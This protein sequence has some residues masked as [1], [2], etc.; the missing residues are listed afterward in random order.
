VELLIGA[1]ASELA[2]VYQEIDGSEQ[3]VIERLV[4]LLI[5]TWKAGPVPAHSLAYTFP[6]APLVQ[7]KAHEV[8]LMGSPARAL[9]N[10]ASDIYLSPAGAIK[11]IGAN[12]CGVALEDKSVFQGN[13]ARYVELQNRIAQ[14]PVALPNRETAFLVL[15]L[16]MDENLN[17]L[18]DASLEDV[19]LYF[20]LPVPEEH[21]K[22][23][24]SFLHELKNAQWFLNGNQVQAKPGLPETVL[25]VREEFNPVKLL[26]REVRGKYNNHFF[27]FQKDAVLK[28]G[29]T[30][31]LP[32]QLNFSLLRM[33]HTFLAALPPNPVVLTIRFQK[34]VAVSND[35]FVSFNCFPVLNRRLNILDT[36]YRHEGLFPL[37]LK[38]DQSFLGVE[39]V[40]NVADE[41]DPFC[42]SPL[43][44]FA[45]SKNTNK[46]SLIHRGLGRYDNFNYWQRYQTLIDTFQRNYKKNEIKVLLNELSLEELQEIFDGQP[47]QKSSP[48]AEN[49]PYIMLQKKENEKQI[50]IK[51]LFW[52]TPGEATNNIRINSELK[53]QE[54]FALPELEKDKMC[55]L[56]PVVGGRSA[57]SSAKGLKLLKDVLFQNDKIVSYADIERFCYSNFRDQIKQVRIGEGTALNPLNRKG[58]RRVIEVGVELTAGYQN[59]PL[60]VMQSI[61]EQLNTRSRSIVPIIVNNLAG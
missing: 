1:C 26:E 35:L 32:G 57:P 60:P 22:E 54:G 6:K 17:A 52:D 42:F 45:E 58:I 38:S 3:R 47:H 61:E 46:Y 11:C 50:R 10:Q 40:Y 33:N 39:S 29:G 34:P 56:K 41:E 14:R 28:A 8:R 18:E 49:G 4:N 15:F 36:W 23:Q 21:H 27:T 37:Q 16:Q 13:L 2:F 31:A 55:L 59:D 30:Q 53:F 7:L 24:A 48:S 43:T 25:P 51:V 5:P 19:S 20:D 12:V 44:S 9:R